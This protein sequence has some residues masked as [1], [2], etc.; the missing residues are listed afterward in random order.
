M[1]LEPQQ[2]Y[3]H[4]EKA[5][6]EQSFAPIYLI[7]GDEPYLITQAMNYLK[8]CAL[9]G[10]ISDFN[11]NSYFASDADVSAIRDE[12]ETL[13]MMTAKRV[14]LVREVE[15]LSDK[16]WDILEPVLETPVESTVLIL[17]G[18][19]IDKRKKIFKV[20]MDKA[21]Y[22]EFKR[23]FENQIPGWIR[24]IAKAHELTV[25]EEALQ[26]FHRL[27]GHQLVEI[28]SEIRKLKDFLG[29]RTQIE[30][31]DVA[32]CVSKTR[33]DSVFDLTEALA[34]A[35]RG[36]SLTFLVQLLDQGQNEVGIVSLVA[37]HVRILLQIK[38]GS[39]QGL[40]GQRLAAFAQV[41]S[42]YLQDYVRQ[43]RLWS[44][45]KLEHILLI[46][47]ETDKALKSSP[48]SAHIWLENMIIK[49]CA[50]Q[51]QVQGAQAPL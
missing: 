47:A 26:L 42:Y 11:F 24:H 45:K 43:S 37:R 36:E 31:E 33:E 30:L 4:V 41:P 40:S 29:S 12:V 28:E 35:Q 9:S 6:A 22:I 16:Q 32:Q 8:T 14:V 2:F 21:H 3:Q 49:V 46:L 17:V 25:S 1:Q 44:L 48:L 34:N 13:P 5:L 20:L 7:S 50:L 23:P 19:K 27:V 51:T 10:G 38:I 15:E 18:G 39:E